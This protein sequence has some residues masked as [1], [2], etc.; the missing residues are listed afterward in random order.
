MSADAVATE[1]ADADIEAVGVVN[2]PIDMATAD[3]V[4]TEGE[5]KST[6]ER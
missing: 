5:E 4:A 2:K 1:A 6:D 3:V